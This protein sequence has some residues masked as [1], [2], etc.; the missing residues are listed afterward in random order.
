MPMPKRT[1]FNG[2]LAWRM[3]LKGALILRH[4]KHK[5]SKRDCG[6]AWWPLENPKKIDKFEPKREE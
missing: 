5:K 4:L 2:D 6:V 1:S 3:D